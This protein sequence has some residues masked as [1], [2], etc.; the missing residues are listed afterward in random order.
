[1]CIA[2]G[3]TT[4]FVTKEINHEASGALSHILHQELERC[5]PWLL[6]AQGLEMKWNPFI[7]QSALRRLSCETTH[8]ACAWHLRKAHFTNDCSQQHTKSLGYLYGC[9]FVFQSMAIIWL[10]SLSHTT[11]ACAQSYRLLYSYSPESKP[12]VPSILNC[13][14]EFVDETFSGSTEAT[15]LSQWPKGIRAN[16]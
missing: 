15:A 3:Q 1:M 16:L 2:P 12:K 14:G 13:D 11:T 4:T 6:H 10:R 5:V 8:T 7:H 9:D